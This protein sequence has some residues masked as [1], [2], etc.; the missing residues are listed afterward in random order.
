LVK[1]AKKK[2]ASFSSKFPPI[3]AAKLWGGDMKLATSVC[4]TILLAMLTLPIPVAAQ[5]S[6]YKLIDIGTLGGPS[7]GLQGNGLGTSHFINSSGT[8]V[9]SS[10]TSIPDV[11]H[12][13]RWQNGVLT[14]LGALP[15]G[16]GVKFNAS[17]A[18]AINA[19]GWIAGFSL[20][21][22]IDPVNGGPVG[23]ALL[24]NSNGEMFDLGT[25][26][27]GIQS[28]GTYINDSGE[29][30]GVATVDTSF[31]PFSFIGLGPFASP[32]HAFLWKNG[33]MRDLGTLGGPDSFIAGLCDDQRAELV[34]GTSFTSFTPN[35]TTGVPTADPFLWKNGTM[36]DLGTLGGTFGGAQCANNQGQVTGTSNLA[37][38]QTSHPFFWDSGVI[39]DIGTFGG[40]NGFPTWM[41]NAGEVVGRADLA[42]GG[43][44]AFLWRDGVM[45]DL[46]T[47]GV[48]STALQIN[49]RHQIIG[50]SRIDE[51][52]VHAFLWENGGPMVDLN[53]LIPPN[54]SLQ[55]VIGFNINDRGEI[56]G[57]GAPPGVAPSGGDAPGLHPFLLIPCGEGTSE[58]CEENG[59][60]NPVQSAQ[61]PGRSLPNTAQSSSRVRHSFN[62]IVGHAVSAD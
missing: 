28:N 48:S 3:Q 19:R 30:V 2:I 9:G 38:D 61:Q 36:I 22:G 60:S 43:H 20:T 35:P 39:T 21:G 17:G 44:D 49:S 13:F 4:A 23:N 55:L 8:V 12:A 33:V 15:G 1:G 31:D 26:G 6:R 7:G 25:L 59:T 34:A 24:W 62:R 42:D 27:T 58:S 52:T 16:S 46:G 10:E 45:T 5:H 29:V 11:F 40:D 32:T 50:A 37:G 57:L 51:N 14:D 53:D 41:N 54:S 47:L 18:N 56:T